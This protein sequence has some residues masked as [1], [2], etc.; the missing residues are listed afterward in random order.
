MDSN[1]T[2]IQQNPQ[3]EN[4]NMADE[5]MNNELSTE[6]KDPVEIKQ[7]IR[8]KSSQ[9]KKPKSNVKKTTNNTPLTAN[10][11]LNL[12]LPTMISTRTEDNSGVKRSVT[13]EISYARSN[14]DVIRLCLRELK[15]KEVFSGTTLDPDIYWHSTSFHDGN[16]NF[17]YSTGRVNKFPGI[18]D[19]LRKVHLTRLLNNM[20][21]LF[22]NE[23][24][25]YPK[26][27]FLPEQNQQFKDD[28]RYI[29]QLDEK[30]NRRLTTFI[31]K[32]SDGSQGEG[33]YLIRDASQIT[34]TTK[35]AH[36]VQE[37]IDRPLLIGG[38]K[39]D[40]RIY[41][42]ILNLYPLEIYLYDEG[43]VRFAT[44]DYKAPSSDNLHETY[45]HLTNYSLN[46]R[47]IHYKHTVNDKQTDGSKRKLSLVWN[48]LN[49]IYGNDKIERTKSLIRELINR[50]MLAVV[51]ELRVEYE[52]Q[53]PLK[54]NP[55]IS[56]FQIIGFDIIL[57]NQVKPIL[58]EV[59][60]NPSLRID[61][62]KDNDDGKIVCQPSL[63][64]EEI[65][66]PLVLETLKLA[67]PK[68]KLDTI[69]RHIKNQANEKLI[70]ERVEKL[71]QRRVEE[72]NEKM[73]N[74]RQSRFDLRLNPYFSRPL[75]MKPKQSILEQQE[76]SGK[77]SKVLD[78]SSSQPI[79]P[80]QSTENTSPY[81]LFNNE[82][83]KPTRKIG[84]RLKNVR[85]SNDDESSSMVTTMIDTFSSL[86]L[87]QTSVTSGTFV[88][89]ATRTD[90]T[91][92][93]TIEKLKLIFS[94]SHQKEY[95][96]L[97]IIDKIGDI[98]IRLVILTGCKFMT[99]GQFRNFASLCE[100]IVESITSST[101][102]ILYCKL[103]KKWQQFVLRTTLTGL[104][105]TAFIEACFIFSQWKFPSA[106]HLLESVNCLINICTERL[107]SNSQIDQNILRQ[108]TTNYNT[109]G[110]SSLNLR[111]SSSNL[112]SSTT[113]PM[114]RSMTRN[115]NQ[116]ILTVNE[117]TRQRT[118]TQSAKSVFPLFFDVL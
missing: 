84:K 98:F 66:K 57:D 35:R 7:K 11:T 82:S 67:L 59:N 100:V 37:Y 53:L 47:S 27:W 112:R 70:A 33:I 91:A 50:T 6:L 48:Q 4:D 45:M 20:R 22:P 62:D 96:H 107:N 75:P 14:L 26:T 56:C 80:I 110:S 61:F 76:Q 104:P 21:L 87:K 74:A 60:A 12:L 38:L 19:L 40:L 94:P 73:K 25:F 95:E 115:S 63:I 93:T 103:L 46:R 16:I 8:S 113:I 86:N 10:G 106:H 68:K 24:D 3:L 2:D 118:S 32:P 5:M 83:T 18:N 43:L 29:H 88:S 42:L 101:I 116:Q 78:V 92:I 81:A 49:G 28:I 51:P 55:N 64:D 85:Y 41:V 79:I 114:R 13:V 72:R 97:F 99:G 117:K 30:Y 105:F 15:W 54:K 17:A 109:I 89:Q 1:D 34:T 52:F 58:L 102:D 44:I 36:V 9:S 71:A 31:V 111:S 39:F 23:Y 65:K 77:E 69:A 108:S 90:M